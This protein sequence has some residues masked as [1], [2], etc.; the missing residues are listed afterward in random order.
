[1]TYLESLQQLLLLYLLNLQL[2]LEIAAFCSVIVEKSSFSPNSLRIPGAIPLCMSSAMHWIKYNVNRWFHFLPAW[3]QIPQLY[4]NLLS[5]FLVGL[6]CQKRP[7]GSYFVWIHPTE[8]SAFLPS[9]CLHVFIF[10]YGCRKPFCPLS[11]SLPTNWTFQ[12]RS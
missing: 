5:L 10:P 7:Q 4:C 2:L 3:F 6:Y 12:I 9:C 8:G 11:R 1:M